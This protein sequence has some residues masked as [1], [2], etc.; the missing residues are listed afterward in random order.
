MPSTTPASAAPAPIPVPASFPITWDRPEDVRLFWTHNGVHF[1]TPITPMTYE[2]MR[3]LFEDGIEAGGRAYDEPLRVHTRRINTYFFMALTAVPT[4]PADAAAATRRREEK[5]RAAMGRLDR[6]WNDE[7]VPEIRRHLAFWDDFDLPAA[8]LPELRSHLDET[9]TRTR[10]LF[11][12]HMLVWYPAMV[13]VSSFE[14]LCR[15]LL[16]Q[17]SSGDALKLLQ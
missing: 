12:I 3:Y 16:G 14:E 2:M 17:G 5:L 7:Y 9:I 15:D 4:A 8:S 10:R 11:D 6:A 13:A 1:P